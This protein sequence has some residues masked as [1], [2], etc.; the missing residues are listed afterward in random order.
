MPGYPTGN[1]QNTIQFVEYLRQNKP[2]QK[3]LLI[4]DGATDHRSQEFRDYLSQ[5]NQGLEKE[6]WLITCLQLAQRCS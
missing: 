2:N 5:I 1:R 6:K 4:G 3:R